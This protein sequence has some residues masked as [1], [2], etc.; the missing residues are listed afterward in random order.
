MIRQTGT[1]PGFIQHV[2]TVLV[3]MSLHRANGRRGFGSQTAADTLSWPRRT[4]EK[5]TAGTVTV[6]QKMLTLQALPSSLNAGAAKGGCLGQGE[7]F[8]CPVAVCPPERPRPFTHYR[9]SWVFLLLR[10][11]PSSRSLG[12]CRWHRILLHGPLDICWIGCPQL[13]HYPCKN[14]THST[15]FFATQGSTRRNVASPALQKTFVNIF[16]VFAWEFC[17][18]KRQGF[19]VNFFWSPSPTKRSTKSPQKIRG[20]FG[21]KFGAEF[22]TRIRKI[23]EAFVLQLF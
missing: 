14:G 21:A 19:L 4:P 2:L 6:S 10:L 7:A 11:S 23:R 3:F 13:P 22:G 17:V 16:F 18:E 1:S 8:G 12:L 5:Q 20:K 15:I 9:M